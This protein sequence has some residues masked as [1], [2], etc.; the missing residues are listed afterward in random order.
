MNDSTPAADCSAD[1]TAK[2]AHLKTLFD[3]LCAC[4]PGA[5]KDVACHA[6]D[7]AMEVGRKAI[8]TVRKHPV[9]AAV[10]AIGAGLLVWWLVNRR[11]N[12]D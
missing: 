12:A 7:K 2:A 10:V 4:A 3:E 11:Q 6:Q 5:A 9:E 8:D 1:F